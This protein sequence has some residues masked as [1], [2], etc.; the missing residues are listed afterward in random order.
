V[1]LTGYGE[2][3]LGEKRPIAGLSRAGGPSKPPDFGL[4]FGA[5]RGACRLA[6]AAALGG[7]FPDPAPSLAIRPCRLS[8][9]LDSAMARAPSA[10]HVSFYALCLRLPLVDQRC[11]PDLVE[12]SKTR[13]PPNAES[14]SRSIAKARTRFRLG[15]AGRRSGS[16]SRAAI[17]TE[18]GSEGPPRPWRCPS[19]SIGLQGLIARM[20]QDLKK[21][22][23]G[24]R[25]ARP[26][27]RPGCSK[28][29]AESGGL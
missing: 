27:R 19:R 10:S 2:Q 14:G 21:R 28:R 5:A 15:S 26:A 22:R 12:P 9:C 11:K 4:P 3:S 8:T 24:G 23:Q 13:S 29:Q 18:H 6:A 16:A 25:A 7:A 17:G 1:P 20:E